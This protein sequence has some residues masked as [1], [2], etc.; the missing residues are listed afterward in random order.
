[1][2]TPSARFIDLAHASERVAG[3]RSRLEKRKILVE[4]LR[5]IP[6]DEIGSAVGWL[7]EQPPGGPTGVGPAQ[8]WK[9]SALSESSESAMPVEP[10]ASLRVVDAAMERAR[11][12]NGGAPAMATVAALFAI[13]TESERRLLVGSLTGSLRQG[14]SEGVML[15]VIAELAGLTE[16]QVQRAVMVKGSAARAAD[17]IL[18]T[19]R[20]APPPTTIELF[21]PLAPM[22]AS[23][24]E[25]L[26]EALLGEQALRVEWKVDGVRAQVHKRGNQVTIYSRAGNDIT[27]GCASLVEPLRALASEALVLDGE[28]VL[29]GP[30]GRARSFQ[31]SFSAISSGVIGLDGSRL[32]I[33][34]FDC[35]HEGGVD[36]V[37]EPLSTRLEMLRACVPPE[38]AMPGI[39]GASVRDGEAARF[40][41]EARARGH[42]GVMVKDLGSTYRSSARGSAWKK[43]KEVATVDL[44]VLAVEPGSGR[45]KG[46]LSN[47]HLGARREDGAFC[48]IGKT[49]KGLTD[50]MLAWQ[51]DKLRALA[52][53]SSDYVVHVRP[54]L[55]VEIRFNDVQRSPR[56][57]GGIALRFARVV[58]YREDKLPSEIE[59]LESLIARLPEGTRARP[60]ARA[61]KPPPPP[62][63]QLSLFGE[64]AEPSPAKPRVG[65]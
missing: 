4:V 6:P 43:V 56:Y 27:R 55:V 42:E 45:R 12:G 46:F 14:S 21:A 24:A 47:L 23:S 1:M 7:T 38:L 63:R 31:D 33:Y 26:E 10:T 30:E 3:T 32:R 53:D 11:T 13:L 5:S 22:L 65:R 20:G 19:T 59:P 48:M 44:V 60:V 8:L 52:V 39:E 57:P 61:E 34:S 40:Y 49:F 28:V 15:P 25:S 37:D 54:E 17:A 50:A 64:A 35:L 41:A 2:D 58:R 51:T 16:A 36:L 9:V 29:E 62:K 18:G